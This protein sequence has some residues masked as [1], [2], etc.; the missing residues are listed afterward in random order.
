[1]IIETLLNLVSALIKTIFS[2]I[3]IPDAPI[4]ITS[5]ITNFLDMIFNNVGFLGFFV[6]I[7][8]LKIVAISAIALITFQRLYTVV[9][10]IYHKLP[11]SSN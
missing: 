2:F 5:A 1:M 11:I 3:N 4:E 7:N 10:W 6:H 9:V 8:V